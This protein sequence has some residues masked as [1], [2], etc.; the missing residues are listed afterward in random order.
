[1][2]L[3][4]FVNGKKILLISPNNDQRVTIVLESTNLF[5]E[6]FIQQYNTVENEITILNDLGFET[7]ETFSSFD[8]SK[9]KIIIVFVSE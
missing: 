6:F 8:I 4:L 1:M 3:N 7:T 5:N 9:G 2:I